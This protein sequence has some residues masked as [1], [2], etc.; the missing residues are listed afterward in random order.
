MAYGDWQDITH[1]GPDTLAG[2][3]L[4]M[5]WQPVYRAQDLPAGRA[6]PVRIMS[7]D[8]TLYR[9]EGGKAYV[10][11]SACGHRGTQLSVGWVEGENV[12]C[13]YHGWMYDGSG[14]CLEQPLEDRPFCE[15]VK[16]RS[17]PAQE[18]LGLIFVYLGGGE[19]P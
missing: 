1:T 12:R 9:G 13:R 5:F 19:A 18:Y 6:V 11:D 4:R 8:L 2:R 3:Y 7:E 17:L 14:Q 16:I 10:V 15:R